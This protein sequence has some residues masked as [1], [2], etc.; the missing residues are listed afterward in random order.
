MSTSIGMS[1]I[2]STGTDVV[3]LENRVTQRNGRKMKT[4]DY[5]LIV[6]TNELAVLCANESMGIPSIYF[7]G[8]YW[9]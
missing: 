3:F 2:S 8:D 9:P 7:G 6:N 4:L 1:H 5:V